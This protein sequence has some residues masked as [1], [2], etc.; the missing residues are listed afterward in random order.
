MMLGVEGSLC[1]FC[2]LRHACHVLLSNLRSYPNAGVYFLEEIKG[3][4]NAT[5]LD[6][7]VAI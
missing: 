5:G 7:K 4:A 6:F 1:T 3:L 2:L